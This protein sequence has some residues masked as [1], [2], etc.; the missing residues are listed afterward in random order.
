MVE[1]YLA[2]FTTNNNCEVINKKQQV[3]MML[4]RYWEL[5]D[6]LDL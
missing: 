5:E 3:K 4:F 1:V 6:G 2:D